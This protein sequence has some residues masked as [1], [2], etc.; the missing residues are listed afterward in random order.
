M[1]SLL[2]IHLDLRC[3]PLRAATALVLCLAPAGLALAQDGGVDAGAPD[4]GVAA[5]PEAVSAEADAGTAT[6]GSE[7]STTLR[8][9]QF[10]MPNVAVP[11]AP[12]P[13]TVGEPS[14]EDALA[15]L[16]SGAPPSDDPTRGAWTA[17]QPIL[18]LHGYLRSRFELQDSFSLGRRPV[19]GT[20]D[21]PF[22]RFRPGE[23]GAVPA[24]GCGNEGRSGSSVACDTNALSYA[25]MR[26]RLQP[27][28]SLSDDVRV[29]AQFDVF[30]NMVWGSTPSGL[31]TLSNGEV[32]RST[33]DGEDRIGFGSEPPETNRNSLRDSIRAKRAW[34]EVTNR[35]L[36]QLRFGRMGWQWG[37]GMFANGGDGIDS[38]FQTDVDRVMGI[39]KIFDLYVMAA[40]DFAD[41]G[42]VQA[43]RLDP[44]ALPYDAL[45]EDDVDQ[46]MLAVAHRAT[47][48]EQ[49]ERLEKGDWVLNAGAFFVYRN[50]LLSSRGVGTGTDLYGDNPTKNNTTFLVRRD[51][52]AF[53]PDAWVQFLYGDLRLELE[54]VLVAG[55]LE[56]KDDTGFVESNFD[57]LQFGL[58]FEGEYRLLEKKLGLHFNFG[59]ASGDQDVEGLTATASD[60]GAAGQQ[61][62]G[63]S[64]PDGTISTFRFHPN[65]RVDLILWRNILQQVSGAYYFKPGIS[66]DFIRN[67]FG[68]LLGL[69]LDF[70]YSR[71]TAPLQTWGNSSN[72]G[73]EIDASVYYRSEDGPELTDGFFAMLQYGVFF[74]MAGLGYLKDDGVSQV[75]GGNPDLSN[76]QTLRIVLGVQY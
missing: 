19:S 69:K 55:S 59:I 64:A 67:S 47:E 15:K 14:A 34:A 35:G 17:P 46:Y 22:S 16:E 62:V 76:A 54:S 51:S 6:E 61:A 70:I 4:S 36:G 68:Q 58:A 32:V 66:Y 28:L 2:N 60:G 65:Y 42:F 48:E 39:T 25:T 50:Q 21:W 53:I 44:Q 8:A 26:F 41:E 24:G 75:A 11:D 9:P 13:E 30:D 49:R 45:Q 18:T 37:L 10:E 27:T 73:L 12:A 72:L 40:Y 23:D 56:N 7:E 20:L 43:N 63:T 5:E 33:A 38:D 31:S 1:P 3:L 29:H 74:P 52:E 57:L 71:A